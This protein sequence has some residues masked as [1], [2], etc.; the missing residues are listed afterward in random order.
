MNP[1]YSLECCL[2][3]LLPYIIAEK[4][5]D[6]FSLKMASTVVIVS[7]Y[8]RPLLTLLQCPAALRLI[9]MVPFHWQPE[10]QGTKRNINR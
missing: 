2:T 3:K 1:P 5:T 10:G 9:A 4:Y 7:A 6:I 8:F